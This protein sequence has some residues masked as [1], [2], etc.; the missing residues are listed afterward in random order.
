MSGAKPIVVGVLGDRPGEQSALVGVM[1]EVVE[2]AVASGR[3]DRPVN[4][5]KILQEQ[6]LIVLTTAH[7]SMIVLRFR[8]IG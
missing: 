2:A 8:Q 4:F 5:V 7:D 1:R 6:L 3:I